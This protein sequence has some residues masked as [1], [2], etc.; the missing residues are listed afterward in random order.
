M[1]VCYHENVRHIYPIFTK[2]GMQQEV[3]GRLSDLIKKQTRGSQVKKKN[4]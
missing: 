2:P 4:L 3:L 1:L